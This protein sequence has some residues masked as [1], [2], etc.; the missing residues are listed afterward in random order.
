MVQPLRFADEKTEVRQDADEEVPFPQ[1]L[2]WVAESRTG[3]FGFQAWLVPHL[4][5]ARA[6]K[7]RLPTARILL[8]G[9]VNKRLHL[10]ER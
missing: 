3:H 7:P 10:R 1:S 5:A 9:A 4:H 8:A 2:E 6:E